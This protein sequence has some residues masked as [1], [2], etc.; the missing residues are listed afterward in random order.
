[1]VDIVKLRPDVNEELVNMLDMLRNMAAEGELKSL[2]VAGM[3]KD[4]SG[5]TDWAGNPDVIR[6][7][8]VVAILQ[9]RLMESRITV[10]VPE[11]GDD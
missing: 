6:Y 10:P 9:Q 5:Y 11:D 7:V 4:N 8:G 1:M 2:A 3:M